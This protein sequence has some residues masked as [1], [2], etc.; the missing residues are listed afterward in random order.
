M[1]ARTRRPREHR[2]SAGH[3][4][5]RPAVGGRAALRPVPP[6]RART[7]AG[8]RRNV[9]ETAA[10]GGADEDLSQG[11]REDLGALPQ[12]PGR[13]GSGMITT[14]AGTVRA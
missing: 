14:R 6:R 4:A 7:P 2:A 12:T 5:A 1:T 8:K 9:S 3:G 11:A 13:S 10:N